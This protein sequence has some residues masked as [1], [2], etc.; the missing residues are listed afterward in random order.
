MAVFDCK[1]IGD[2]KTPLTAFRAAIEDVIDPVSGKP[3]FEHRV[4]AQKDA[5][6]FTVEA[7][8]V[9]GAANLL[10]GNPDV[11]AVAAP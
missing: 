1:I 11:I 6:T 3:A 7:Q 10:I 2:G 8:Q 4:I 9:R 5:T